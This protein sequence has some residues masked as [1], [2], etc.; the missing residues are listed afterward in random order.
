M[1]HLFIVLSAAVLMPCAV[2]AQDSQ[3]ALGAFG[4][5]RS[6]PIEISADSL[7]VN[8]TDGSATFNGNVLIGQ[9]DMRISAGVVIVEYGEGDDGK[10]T[11]RKLTASGGVTL[12]SPSEAAEANSAV[13]S[14]TDG[15]V[16]LSGDVLLTQGP[17][18]ISGDRLVV[19]LTDGSGSITGNVRTLLNPGGDN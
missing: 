4:Y 6:K 2:W 16:A 5:D 8:Q 10:T 13:Y 17:T 1:R 3:V 14:V 15:T 18:A 11:I 7:D 12:V 19:N 9:A